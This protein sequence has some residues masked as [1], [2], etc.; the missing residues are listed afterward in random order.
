MT[1]PLA[2][3]AQGK[4]PSGQLMEGWFREREGSPQAP[5]VEG[6]LGQGLSG[7]GLSGLTGIHGI[8]K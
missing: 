1:G 5:Q 3:P 7:G 2:G 4:E 6:A 8:E